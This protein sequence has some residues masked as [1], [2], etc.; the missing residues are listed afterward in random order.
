MT[1]RRHRIFIKGL[2]VDVTREDL[3]S[4]F[5]DI[6]PV[7]I[8]VQLFDVQFLIN[9]ISRRKVRILRLWRLKRRMRLSLR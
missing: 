9:L 1:A 5:S 7:S 3:I 4:L 6:G 8:Q 2:S